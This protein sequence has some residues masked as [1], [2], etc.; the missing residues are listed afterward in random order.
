MAEYENLHLAAG[1]KWQKWDR[2]ATG[3]TLT[4]QSRNK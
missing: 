1:I 2:S 4:T 3:H